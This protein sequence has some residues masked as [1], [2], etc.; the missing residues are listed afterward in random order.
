[1]KR[2]IALSLVDWITLEPLL[3]Q[4]HV[5]DLMVAVGRSLVVCIVAKDGSS[6]VQ[7]L[8]ELFRICE[9]LDDAGEQF[10][11]V[12]TARFYED[13]GLRGSLNRQS[14]SLGVSGSVGCSVNH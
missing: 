10:G 5:Y 12:A 6:V 14:V 9:G 7:Q 3:I 11:I 13:F 2:R 1:M 8:S 4:Q